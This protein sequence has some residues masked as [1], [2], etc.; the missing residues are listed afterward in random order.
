MVQL[1]RLRLTNL[2]SY[3]TADLTLPPGTTLLAGDVGSGKTSILYAIEMAL[4]GFAEVDPTFLVRHHAASAEVRLELEGDGHTY[5]FGRRFRRRT[6][7]GR[8]VFELES[9]S[10]AEDG[11]RSSYS[12]TEI[13]ERAIRLLGFPDNPNP[14]AHSDLWRWAVYVPQERMRDVLAQDPEERLET[15]RK[16]LGL[17]Q[18]RTAA[19]NAQLLASELR[20][21]ADTRDA[22]ARAYDHYADERESLAVTVR[23][24]KEEAARLGDERDRLRTDAEGADR[25][26]AALEA[27]RELVE[28]ARAREAEVLQALRS[29]E[30]AGLRHE[31]RAA[32]RRA[33]TA[34]L[35]LLAEGAA[36]RLRTLEGLRTRHEELSNHLATASTERRE[37]NDALE[38]FARLDGRRTAAAR[39]SELA[40]AALAEAST[41]LSAA[42]AELER[43]QADGP[44]KEPPAPTRRSLSEI[45]S[46]LTQL[47]TE[48]NRAI[49]EHAEQ[50]HV[51]AEVDELLSAGVC[52]R[53]HQPVA[54]EGFQPHRSEVA[55]AVRRTQARADTLRADLVGCSEERRARERYERSF[56]RW[57]DVERT[58]RAARDR[59]DRA[60]LRWKEAEQ[61]RTVADTELAGVEGLYAGLRPSVDRFRA[62]AEELARLEVER[63]EIDRRLAALAGPLEE[64]RAAASALARLTEDEAVDAAEE[65]DRTAR[66]RSLEARR[67][68]LE[69]RLASR[70]RT[71]ADLRAA[72]E[73]GR[74]ARE[75]MDRVGRDAARAEALAETTQRQLHENDRRL[76]ERSR[77]LGESSRRRALAEWFSTEFRTSVL[78]LERRLL[79]R[80]QTEFERSFAMFFTVLVEDPALVARCD[81]S[82]APSVEIDG[83]WTPVEA[84]SGGERTAL[85]LAFR[86]ALG[87]VVRSAGRLALETLI[88]D[89]PTDG[90]SPEQ[91]I[92]MGELLDR[93]ALP[94]VLLVSHESQLAAAADRVVRVEKKDG[95]SIL[96][97]SEEDTDPAGPPARAERPRRVRTPRLD[98]EPEA[99]KGRAP[100]RAARAARD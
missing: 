7:R 88:L 47:Q 72:R 50:A 21:S 18:Y 100:P 60:Q 41:E 26:V 89:E 65:S 38:E 13:R 49:G 6:R 2:R 42:R 52:P 70:D 93:L 17:E 82:F 11:Q 97:A 10:Y 57:E 95:R 32:A 22:T 36:E 74:A 77:L 14:R 8:E 1:R 76:E 83:E 85:A 16:A 90:F 31:Q 92:R 71:M 46:N 55:E 3:E 33:E 51:L 39:A 84:L 30:D 75:R 67:A 24:R 23:T 19:E 87:G 5:E 9:A 12:V 37:A 94:Q 58:R 15:V 4:F 25:T 48:L 44:Q 98:D 43:L 63:S 62:R 73:R 29:E 59:C 20:R 61:R 54:S 27:E 99:V 80:A 35:R 45:D 78:Q 40:Q 69:P 56:Q 66:I 28:E 34:R 79:A 68:E 64:D 86:L 91:V 53:C 96:G 81:A